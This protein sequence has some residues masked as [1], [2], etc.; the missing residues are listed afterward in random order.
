M[1]L[2]TFAE[3]VRLGG[4]DRYVLWQSAFEF[5]VPERVLR[6]DRGRI[7]AF[8]TAE[9]AREYAIVRGMTLGTPAPGVDLTHDLDAISAW[10]ACPDASS[11]DVVAVGYEWMFLENAGILPSMYDDGL[12]EALEQVVWQLDAAELARIDPKSASLAPVWTVEE[13]ALLAETLR[14]G[15]EEF[16]NAL[17]PAEAP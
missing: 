4:V 13:L 9:A 17:S 8:A 2:E 7:P 10:A 11:L 6:D 15:V 16:G 12:G 14:R 1:T 5:E 3:P